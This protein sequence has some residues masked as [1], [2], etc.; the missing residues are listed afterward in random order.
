M[1]N[2]RSMTGESQA[3]SEKSFSSVQDIL[4]NYFP[5]ILLGIGL[6]FLFSAGVI[7]YS[8]PGES[9]VVFQTQESG[10][11]SATLIRVDVA[12]AVM[13][14]GVYSF[15]AG[16][17]IDEAIA[18]ASG[19]SPNADTEWM[20]K[21]LNRAAKLADGGKI[22]IPQRGDIPD[23]TSQG[24]QGNV[25]G[26]E[27]G[28]VNI[29]LAGQAQLET[30]PGIGPVTAGKIISGRPY[31]TTEELKTKKIVGSAVFEKIKHQLTL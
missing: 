25:A 18:A 27:T 17:R 22:Y 20:A 6:V 29:N 7:A 3:S 24:D 16:S 10:T 14:P 5:F 15:P 19:L 31:Q 30:L 21:N 1:K 11:E 12:G 9:D 23:G 26:V 8:A 2:K 4:R 13:Q 28:L